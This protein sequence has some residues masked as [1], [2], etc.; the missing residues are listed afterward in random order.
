MTRTLIVSWQYPWPKSF[1]G[2]LRTFNFYRFFKEMG[3]VDIVYSVLPQNA[4]VYRSVFENEYFL[5]RENFPQNNIEKILRITKN[6][7]YPL[8]AFPETEQMTFSTLIEENDYD[9]IVARYIKSVPGLDKLSNKYMRR[10]IIDFDDML[11]GSLYDTL[12]SRKKNL[13]AQCY[14][15]LNR[16]LLKKFE[17]GC[18][19]FGASLFCS[20]TDRRAF[21]G[22]KKL[23]NIFVVPNIF[24]D[25]TFHDFEFG[26]GA[27]KENNLLFIGSL[28]YSA[29][30][31]GLKWF[32]KKI[33]PQ[34]KKQFDN[35]KLSVVGHRPTDEIR[36]LCKNTYN[37]D[38]FPDV[39]D[40]K[41]Y[42]QNC[43][44]VIVPILSGGGTRIKILEAALAKR[45]I[46]STP[47]GAEG[48]DMDDEN[49]ILIFQNAK[50]FCEKYSR[51]LN[52]S[53]Y[54]ELCR[55]AEMKVKTVYSWDNFHK[56]MDVVINRICDL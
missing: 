3:P 13:V 45:G 5:Q 49:E 40:V 16:A 34:A 30:I 52:K 26:D 55:N 53:K 56:K 11:S 19:K 31:E 25:N 43:F 47:K 28:S 46:L 42:Y 4:E 21:S 7:P 27:L 22:Y 41:E 9:F 23:K 18:S 37:V 20:E 39:P 44:A 14:R 54:N 24:N 10:S 6:I 17:Q 48:L 50:E 35:L 8:S 12:F 36:I 33:F 1:G 29:N 15:K 38:L 32:I 51:L 2:S